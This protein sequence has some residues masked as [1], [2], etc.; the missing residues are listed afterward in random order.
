MENLLL[1]VQKV[2]GVAL[3]SVR[4][5]RWR[6][7]SLCFCALLMFGQLQAQGVVSQF[8]DLN[9]GPNSS[10]GGSMLSNA[11]AVF[12]DGRTFY[13][14]D[15]GQSGIELWVTDG[16]ALNT[17][18]FSDICPGACS[19][20]PGEFYIENNTLYFAA[21][22]GVHGVELWRLAASDSAPVLLSDINPGA[23]GSDP[24]LFK[25]INFRITT[26]P[27]ARTFFTATRASE[28]RELWR[29]NAASNTVSL[30]LDLAPGPTSS[31]PAGFTTFNT[32]DVGLTAVTPNLRRAVYTLDY[33]STTAPPT[34]A[35]LMTVFASTSTRAVGTELVTLANNT[36]VNISVDG[37]PDE[38]WITQG[39]NAS[40][41]L[42]RSADGFDQFVLNVSLFRTFF[43]VRTGG[44]RTLFVS[45]ASI[46]G[47]VNLGASNPLLMR[48]IGNR[49]L[50]TAVTSNGDRELFSSDGTPAGTGLLKELVT[51]S[52]GI[53]TSS[54]E[55]FA[56]TT[57]S[58]VR[59]LLGFGNQLW[60]SDASAAGTVLLTG[61]ALNGAGTIRALTATTGLESLLAVDPSLNFSGG[62]PFYNRGT[63]LSNSALGNFYSDVGDSNVLPL[64]VVNGRLVANARTPSS[65]TLGLA[66]SGA[67]APEI[68]PKSILY[69]SGNHFGRLWSRDFDGLVTTDGTS[70][71]SSVIA[72]V[73]PEMFGHECV[74]ERNGAGYFI[75]VG[76]GALSDAGAEIFR[77]D[78]SAAGTTVVTDL[79]STAEPSVRDI[80]GTNFRL[81]AGMGSQ[82]F[83]VAS[84][85]NSGLELH[86]LNAA[87][88]P[89]LI[90]DIR[91]GSIGSN[92][93]DML[94]LGNRLLISADDGVFGQEL[95]VSNGTGQG[96]LRLTD[97]APG[98]A[99]SDPR[100]LIRVGNLAYFIA[101]DPTN[102]RELYVTDGTAAGTR[103]VQD[104]YAGSGSAFATYDPEFQ[105]LGNKLIFR[106]TGSAQ[107]NCRLYETDG[108]AAGTRC[109]YDSAALILG[110]INN[111]VVAGN[112]ALVFSAHRAGDGEELRVLFNR[113]ILTLT[114]GDVAPG[115]ASSAP[116]NLLADGND[117]Y[118][119]ANNGVTG[120][121]LWK[122]A[123]GDLDSLFRSGF[124]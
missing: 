68:L 24:K 90:A 48:A 59:Y 25:R 67:A 20:N 36:Y 121:E 102:G 84:K 52:A 35:T 44:V 70:A 118:F 95:W 112:G 37:A 33:A 75:G 99:S 12:F 8:A 7:C 4:S 65:Q 38:L 18:L 91:S 64:A 42:L 54:F 55:A 5:F 78:G 61:G 10:P 101:F 76:I 14:A 117:V 82:L 94:S 31:N 58:P 41:F 9:T 97:I 109:A 72:N 45:D 119:Q 85:S 29:L 120:I 107:P 47:T 87:D 73:R 69:P 114:G 56:K 27:Q 106:A 80:C 123:L 79:S 46:A 111:V 124:E 32:L 88:Q 11:N 93:L 49:M 86:A 39:T 115:S 116:R 19:S 89:S 30:E 63:A 62:E 71:G 60:L 1:T 22:D 105:V 104:L 122:L 83:F 3:H 57:A 17:R 26:T 98:A 110:P 43:T 108:T 2:F 15:N 92:I 16:T 81:I 100:N 66:L 40:S 77:S 34:G 23:E 113:Q 96:T 51:G 6:A 103:L 53:P 28:G 50:F 74:V 13:A 21:D